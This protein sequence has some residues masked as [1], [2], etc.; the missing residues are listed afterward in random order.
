MN[1][2]SFANSIGLSRDASDLRQ[3]SLRVMIDVTIGFMLF[4][5]YSSLYFWTSLLS[6]V[7]LSSLVRR[8]F[9]A[10]ATVRK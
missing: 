2:V 10:F 4:V 1:F 3:D 8:P 7:M 6:R 9:I 5:T